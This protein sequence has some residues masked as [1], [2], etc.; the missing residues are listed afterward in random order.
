MTDGQWPRNLRWNCEGQGC[1]VRECLPNWGVLHGCFLRENVKPTDIDGL[2]HLADPTD[3]FLI[4]EKK[5]V[6]KPLDTGQAMALRAL[7]RLPGVTILVLRGDGPDDVTQM[8][9]HPAQCKQRG[10]SPSGWQPASVH[11]VRMFCDDWA[12]GNEDLWLP[13]RTA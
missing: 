4:I 2:V 9:W 1:Y 6:G 13:R 3:R 7:N 11:D 5:P 10:L 12:H 8:L